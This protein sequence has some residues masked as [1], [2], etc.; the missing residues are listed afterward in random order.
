MDRDAQFGYINGQVKDHQG[1]N[2]PVI[3][4][5]TKKKEQVGN[6]ANAGRE[7]RPKGRPV[8]VHDHDFPGPAGPGKAVPYGIYDLAANTG[9]VNVAPTLT[10][11]RSRW[12]RSAAGG[13]ARARSPTRTPAGC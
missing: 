9:W 4:V 5:D 1:S 10:P 6:Y 13:R 8:A 12:N 7:Y 3:S 11:R 2:D